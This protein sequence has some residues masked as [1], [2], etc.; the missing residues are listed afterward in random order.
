MGGQAPPAEIGQEHAL[1]PVE[2]VDQRTHERSEE[3]DR[4]EVQG[5]QD[6]EVDP[7]VGISLGDHPP[8]QG[9]GEEFVPDGGDQPAGEEV[10]EVTEE[11][12]RMIAGDEHPIRPR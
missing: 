12:E 5:H 8:G 1:P 9:D 11:D 7:A 6:P 3:D 10:A 4:E 2:P